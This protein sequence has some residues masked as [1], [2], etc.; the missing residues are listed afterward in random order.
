MAI[1]KDELKNLKR[2]YFVAHSEN[3]ELMMEPHCYCGSA[4]ENEYYCKGC[5]HQCNCT[6]IACDDP[7]ALA[8]VERLLRGNPDFQKFEVATLGK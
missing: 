6:F 4:L 2:D 7:E 8:M 1:T 3:G 5:N